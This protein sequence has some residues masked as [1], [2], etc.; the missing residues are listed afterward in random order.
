MSYTG[1][2]PEFDTQLTGEDS[3]KVATTAFVQQ[4]IN[5]IPAGS[6][7]EPIVSFGL[8]YNP[9]IDTHTSVQDVLYMNGNMTIG[10]GQTFTISANT[11]LNIQ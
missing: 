1:K 4:E 6:L 3:D 11:T 7:N 9:V 5:A 2:A 10:V 8:A